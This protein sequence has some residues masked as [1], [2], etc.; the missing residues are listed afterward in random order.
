I[1]LIER[2]LL[3]GFHNPPRLANPNYWFVEVLGRLRPGARLARAQAELELT[4]RQAAASLPPDPDNHGEL[5][6]IVAD[7]AAHGVNN[8]GQEFTVMAWILFTLTGLV[9]LIVGLN[10]ASLLLARATARAHEFSVRLAIGAGRFALIRQLLVESWVLAACGAAVSLPVALA[11][12]RAMVRFFIPTGVVIHPVLDARTL[13]GAALLAL[14]AALL[15]GLAPALHAT[16]LRRRSS[17][18][19]DTPHAS[20]RHRAGEIL[21]VAQVALC[22]LVLSGAGLFL[23]TLH[24]LRSAPVG[25]D[26]NNVT[27]FHVD[28]PLEGY[29]G[30]RL[31]AFYRQVLERLR[32]SPGISVATATT[33]IPGGTAASTTRNIATAPNQPSGANPSTQIAEIGADFFATYRITLLAGREFSG[34]DTLAAPKVAIVNHTM[35]ARFTGLP[36]GQ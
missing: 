5:P 21:L 34:A 12:T 23:R 19:S 4:A 32:R 3:Q 29:S 6:V 20:P 18:L 2:N 9:M 24:N 35:A 1:S 22:L 7:S 28:P 33:I 10:L 8:L 14:A 13:A 11:A 16:R 30:P 15:I 26:P 17:L 31:D 27:L 25:L 36:L